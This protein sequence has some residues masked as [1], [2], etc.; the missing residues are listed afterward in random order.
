MMTSE[1]AYRGHG[2]VETTYGVFDPDKPV[3][4]LRDI[5]HALGQ[6]TRYNGHG[7]F[8]Y[9]VAE[10]SVMVSQ[11][12]EVLDLGDPME[13]L[14]HDATEA[15]LSDVPAPFKQFLPDLQAF[16]AR[17]EL[18]LRL[19][20]GLPGTKS[21]GIKKADWLALYIEAAELLPSGGAGWVDPEGLRPQALELRKQGWVLAGHLPDVATARFHER[22]RE[23][24]DRGY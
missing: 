18:A 17:M 2:W 8:F 1:E 11:L 5:G 21:R 14:L 15:Y 7:K 9:S 10:H 19:Q 16:D 4:D 24:E 3:F 6:L 22:F 13:G 20:F 23:L 12:V